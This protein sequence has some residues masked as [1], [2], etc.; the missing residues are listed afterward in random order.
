MRVLNT[1][2]EDFNSTAVRIKVSP[3]GK[4]AFDVLLGYIYYYKV[5]LIRNVSMYDGRHGCGHDK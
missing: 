2:V 3:M 5:A 4:D 1:T